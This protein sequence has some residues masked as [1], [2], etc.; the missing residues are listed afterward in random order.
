MINSIRKR[1]ICKYG[2]VKKHSY[3]RAIGIRKAGFSR[4]DCKI[5]KTIKLHITIKCGRN[6]KRND[7]L[8]YFKRIKRERRYIQNFCRIP[9]TD[10]SI[11]SQAKIKRAVSARNPSG[12]LQ[13]NRCFFQNPPMNEYGHFTFF[14]EQSWIYISSCV[15]SDVAFV[16][17]TIRIARHKILSVFQKRLFRFGKTSG[18]KTEPSTPASNPGSKKY[19]VVIAASTGTPVF[20]VPVVIVVPLFVP[21]PK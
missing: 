20:P 7:A 8:P 21:G 15:K 16:S 3:P 10:A 4:H 19:P 12:A 17:V 2:I 5:G 1:K 11:F 14:R 6:G 13:G 18:K 9:R